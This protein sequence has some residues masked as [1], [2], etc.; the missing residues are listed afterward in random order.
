VL[1]YTRRQLV[2]VVSLVAGG[3]FGLAIDHWRHANPDVVAYLEMLDRAPATAREPVAGRVVARAQDV[4]HA[5]A[6]APSREPRVPAPS[7][8]DGGRAR[9]ARAD[10]ATPLDV[11]LASASELERLPGVGPALAARIVDVRAREGPFGSV[12]ELRRVRGV[13]VATLER[14]RPRLV[15]NTP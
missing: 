10:D 11:N 3:A 4:P 8:R 1:G 7:S 13:G 9:P 14:L 15:V 12:D 5:R 6:P 2:I